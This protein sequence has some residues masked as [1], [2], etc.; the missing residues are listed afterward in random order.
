MKNSSIGIKTRIKKK[1]L[2]VLNELHGKNKR[3]IIFKKQAGILRIKFT[4]QAKVIYDFN[5]G[6]FA[7]IKIQTA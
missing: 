1:N 3:K 5:Y 2:Q 7:I 4:Q 6:E